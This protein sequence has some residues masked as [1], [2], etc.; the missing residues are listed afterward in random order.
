MLSKRFTKGPTDDTK[1][2]RMHS[3]TYSPS[4]PPRNGTHSGISPAATGA[5][6]AY[7]SDCI[8]IGA[9][10]VEMITQ[11]LCGGRNALLQ[12]SRSAPAQDRAS[13]TRVRLQYHH[14]DVLWPHP[15]RFLFD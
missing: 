3:S 6:G 9:I 10:H 13:K 8:C 15:L 11:P 4:F 1:F 5:P 12:R 7:S 2:V 14:F